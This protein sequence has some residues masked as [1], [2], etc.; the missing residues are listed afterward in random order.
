[1]KMSGIELLSILLAVAFFVLKVIGYLPDWSYW[2][3]V[4]VFFAP[5]ILFCA[6]AG[7]GFVIAF[8]V[9]LFIETLKKK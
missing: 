5:I 1:M 2:W 4:P 3:I 6:V 8:L 9:M 7:V